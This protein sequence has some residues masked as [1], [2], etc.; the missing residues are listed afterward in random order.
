MPGWLADVKG[1]DARYALLR[2]GSELAYG[3]RELEDWDVV[4]R[5]DELILLEAPADWPAPTDRLWPDMA[6]P[7]RSGVRRRGPQAMSTWED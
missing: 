1:I 2:T 4:G 5:S 3:L 6:G 7:R